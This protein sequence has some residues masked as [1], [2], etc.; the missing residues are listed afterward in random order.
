[1]KTIKID[2]PSCRC[3]NRIPSHCAGKTVGCAKCGSRF[4]VPPAAVELISYACPHCDDEL[5]VEAT[6]VGQDRVCGTCRKR[7]IVPDRTTPRPKSVSA[8]SLTMTHRLTLIISSI[9]V[10]LVFYLISK[11]PQ[12]RQVGDWRITRDLV[13]WF[14]RRVVLSRWL[15]FPIGIFLL[16]R[17][18]VSTSP[19][20]GRRASLL[21]Y[22]SLA[23]VAGVV[24]FLLSY[25]FIFHGRVPIQFASAVPAQVPASAPIDAKQPSAV[26]PNS[27]PAPVA[28][29]VRTQVAATPNLNEPPRVAAAPKLNEPAPN[30]VAAADGQNRNSPDPQI[31]EVD[32]L[33]RELLKY[34]DPGRQPLSD[35][36]EKTALDVLK[37]IELLGPK[38]R[39]ASEM[40]LLCALHPKPKSV[41]VGALDTLEIV[42]PELYSPITIL[43]VDRDPRNHALAFQKLAKLG[44][45]AKPA[46]PLLHL[47]SKHDIKNIDKYLPYIDKTLQFEAKQKNIS[48]RPTFGGVDGILHFEAKGTYQVKEISSQ[49]YSFDILYSLDPN[50]KRTHAI[51]Y[52]LWEHD[53]FILRKLMFCKF[54][55]QAIF[56]FYL[57]KI[58]KHK[59]YDL[60]TLLDLLVNVCKKS[61]NRD[62][63]T[64]SILLLEQLGPAAVDAL[65]T[66]RELKLD[67]DAGIRK[68]AIAAIASIANPPKA[69]APKSN[70]N[71]PALGPNEEPLNPAAQFPIAPVD[72]QNPIAVDPTKQARKIQSL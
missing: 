44:Q 12:G 31:S 32:V 39:A 21:G 8:G 35:Q 23:C 53:I 43:L 51:L 1:M 2:C 28:Q 45:D 57:S 10:V 40:L 5:S 16:Y 29:P 3:L 71:V 14:S 22:L 34:A 65:P 38:A 46:A 66:L 33:L 64:L 55:D 17:L 20:V 69:A 7:T 18:I 59:E 52:E 9:V 47:I 24:F 27:K 70:Q 63:R 67:P 36:E 54:N 13:E 58:I 15:A 11:T 41:R 37:R 6:A 56:E 68:A 60:K 42:N 50:N 26:A 25:I 72:A 30:P 48:P 19:L 49:L 61:S 4:P 62:K